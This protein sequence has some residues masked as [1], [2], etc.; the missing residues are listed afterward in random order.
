MLGRLASRQKSLFPGNVLA[1]MLTIF[2]LVMAGLARAQSLTAYAELGN[3]DFG[4]ISLTTAAFTETG[5]MG[6]LLSALGVGPGGLLYGGVYGNDTLYQVDPTSGTLTSVGTSGIDYYLFGSTTTGVYGLD[7]D[8]NLYSVNTTTAATTFIGSTG[9][10]RSGTYGMSTGSNTLYFTVGNPS[11]LYSVNTSTGATT[12][13]G[14]TGVDEIGAMVFENGTLYA[15]SNGSP[16]ALYTL[17]TSTGAGTLVADTNASSDFWGL[18]PAVFPVAGLSPSSLKL[19]S[20]LVGQ[21]SAASK[22]T[23][24]N[25]GSVSLSIGNV[26]VSGDFSETDTCAGNTI[27]PT[28]TCTISVTFTPSVTGSI[29]GTLNI[30]DNAVNTPQALALSGTGLPPV[31]ISP[32]SAS[33]GTVTVGTTSTAKAVTLTNNTAGTVVYT[34]AASSN[35]AAV[36]SGKTP[37]NGTL[38]AKK[39]CTLSV[40]FTPTAN[41]AAEGSLSV[42]SD[43]FATQLAALSGTGS[44]GGTSPLT[45]APATFKVA[46]TL[47]GA[48]SSPVTVTVTNSSDSTVNITNFAASADYS[49]QGSGTSPCSGNLGAG[50]SCT[51]AVTFNP[52]VAGTLK[53]SL[54]FMDNASVN[55]QLYE[56]SGTAV[57]PVSF[58]PTSLTFSSQAL[59]KTSAAKTIK[60]TNNQATALTLSGITASGQYSATPGGTEACGTTVNPHTTCTIEV[61]F[62]PSESGTIPG[63]IT[64]THNATGSPQTIKLS[65][66]GQ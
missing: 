37:C 20:T 63:A 46:T 65:G 45:F 38:A 1:L 7:S 53:G 24:T 4:T 17:D 21:T 59:G 43:S 36:G 10:S 32:A 57:L 51:V 60:L 50:A 27:A 8:F 47:V 3:D 29:S 5:D 28:D 33:F 35:F 23:L 56:L 44:G 54:V 14:S 19:P 62:T 66:T 34:P 25:S 15:G 64:V 61:T 41:G 2:L 30:I 16:L 55:T 48:S 6:Q 13:I 52:S 12:E 40:T 26:S 9:L 18:A 31:S 11:V 49:V 39:K 58:S 42:S 22:V